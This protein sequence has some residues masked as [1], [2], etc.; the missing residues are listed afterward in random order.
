MLIVTQSLAYFF[1]R[2]LVHRPLLCHGS[3]SAA[4]AAGIVLAAAGKHVL[5]ILDLLDERRMNYT[6]PLSKTDLL[7]NSGLAILWQTLDLEDDSKLVKDNQKSLTMAVGMLHAENVAV[8]VEFQQVAA[9]IIT[10]EAG[11]ALAR[12]TTELASAPTQ[13]AAPTM[14]APVDSKSKSA[15]KQLQAIASRWSSFSSKGKPDDVP[16]RAT[17][18]QA[19]PTS[20]PPQVHRA[21]STVSL[22]STR[23]APVVLPM[24]TLSPRQINA[25]NPLGTPTINLDYFPIGDDFGDSQ[26]RTSSSTMLPP[27]KQSTTPSLADNSGWD[28]LL[29][30][31]DPNNASVY[32]DLSANGHTLYQVPSNE[33]APDTWQLSGMDLPTKAPVP[34]SLLSFSE[35]SL[36]SNDDFL[37][38]TAGSHSGSIGPGDSL[39]LPETY[40]GITIPIDDGFDFHE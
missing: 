10:V 21:G 29:D 4:S 32:Q 6:F 35:E 3:G 12:S 9:C 24:S 5:Q 23:S 22:S 15:R 25:P 37:F 16:R 30:G 1:T 39:E 40:R 14:S 33:W 34:Q 18:P 7:L 20:V 31:L 19:G 17:V 11:S 8:A 13:S 36:T 2:S 26:T 28:H 38:S 27:K